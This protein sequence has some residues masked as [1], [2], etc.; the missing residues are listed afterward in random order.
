MFLRKNAKY[1]KKRRF[2]A[3]IVFFDDAHSPLFK[4]QKFVGN[5]AEIKVQKDPC[6]AGKI[7]TFILNPLPTGITV[8]NVGIFSNASSPRGDFGR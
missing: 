6:F 5:G 1:F 3:K 7:R 4:A 2:C 8:T